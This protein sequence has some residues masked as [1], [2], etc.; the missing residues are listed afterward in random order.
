MKKYFFEQTN[1]MHDEIVALHDFVL[2]TSTALYHFRSVIVDELA[3]RPPPSVA[4]LAQKYNVAPGTRGSTNLR[5]PFEAHSWEMQR[6]RLAEVA[7]IGV[8]ALYEMWCEQICEMFGRPELAV[9]LQFPTNASATKGIRFA[10]AELST[11]QSQ[12]LSHV[13]YPSLVLAKKYA[14]PTLDNLLR[15][16]RY[17]KELRN[18]LMHRGRRCDGKLFGAQSDFTPIANR[19]GLGMAFVPAYTPY[20]IGDQVSLELHGVLGFTDVILQII[21]TIDAEL[22]KTSIAEGCLIARMKAENSTPLPE[23]K[24]PRALDTMGLKGVK[25]TTEFVRFMRSN[26]VIVRG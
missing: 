13:V 6:E 22:T 5:T 24:L 17:F 8:I 4:D 14:L 2:P 23:R 19:A 3:R 20:Q 21:T 11:A 7:L 10:L 1:A 25:C 16:F 12:L 26:N 18:S 15:C 9:K